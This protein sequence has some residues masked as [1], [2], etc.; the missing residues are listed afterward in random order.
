MM[1][2]ELI[3]KELMNISLLRPFSICESC[4]DPMALYERQ[5][6]LDHSAWRCTTTTCPKYQT[7][8]SIREGS[9]FENFNKTDL[10]DILTTIF[11]FSQEKQINTVVSDFGISRYL[12]M[13]IYSELRHAITLHLKLHPILLGGEGVICQID[14]S[15]FSHKVKSHKG[16]P[17]KEDR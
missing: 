3:V 13:K 8:K 16:R 15:L 7:H 17:P 12:V 11:C 9:F 10:K 5:D 6:T 2:E 1:P 14:E 4:H